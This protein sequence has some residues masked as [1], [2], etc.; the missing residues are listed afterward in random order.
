MIVKKVLTNVVAVAVLAAAG[1][2]A[3]VAAAFALYALLCDYLHP[4]GAAAI[5]AGAA[6]LG[7]A[8]GALAM[9]RKANPPKPAAADESLTARLIGMARER[10]V[11]AVAAAVAVGVIAFRNPK[12]VAAL[13]TGL[14]AGKA[15]EKN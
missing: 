1:A 4:A 7:L 15:S 6:A 14:M 3:V 5:V 11:V 12:L 2:V 13:M 8:L 10:P 9:L